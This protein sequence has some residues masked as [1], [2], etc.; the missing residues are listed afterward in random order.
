[1]AEELASKLGIPATKLAAF[2]EVYEAQGPHNARRWEEY[3]KKVRSSSEVEHRISERPELLSSLR[4]N[5]N[6][7]VKAKE[8]LIFCGRY[9]AK[10]GT[11]LDPALDDAVAGIQSAL[12]TASVVEGGKIAF[13]VIHARCGDE[14]IACRADAFPYRPSVSCSHGAPVIEAR[15][16][17]TTAAAKSGQ[18]LGYVA[19]QGNYVDTI[20]VFNAFTGQ[21]IATALLAAAA[22]VEVAK[23]GNELCLDV[24]AA[25]VPAISM[26]KSLGFRF[27]SITFPGFLDWD[28]GFEGSADA[29]MV[30]S[31]LPNNA[32]IS[33][34]M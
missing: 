8:R 28:G 7:L 25:N 11:A 10:V 32:D 18:L 15:A 4:L 33:K 3:L 23:G 2:K 5:E 20:E 6:Q 30:K 14:H 22:H 13:A 12:Q 1:M 19:M 29:K 26:Y 34:L 9:S 16:R 24:R 27:G 21:G 31:K 17:E